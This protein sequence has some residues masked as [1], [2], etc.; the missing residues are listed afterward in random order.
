[1][2]DPSMPPEL[3]PIE[4]LLERELGDAAMARAFA[5]IVVADALQWTPPVVDPAEVESIVAYT[6]GNRI[7]H[8][9]N[10]SP[11]PVNDAL[12]DIVT[13]LHLET[14]APVY[15]QWEIAEAVGDR[16]ATSRLISITPS[17][18]ARGG[19]VYLS[20][21]GVAAAILEKVGDARRL[22]KVAVVGFADHLKRSVDTSRRVGMD[23]AAPAGYDM[24][25]TYDPQSGQ[26]W[27]RSRLVY[28]VHDVCCR[29]EDRRNE[30]LRPVLGPAQGNHP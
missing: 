29:A 7:D 25:N 12:A 27:T 21:G 20:T 13:R 8:N 2:P 23:A 30:L 16:I 4:A 3:Q 17:R 28:L 11:G 5:G 19:T 26:P 15:A 22:G 18:D 1:M 14:G 10:R 9:G 6:F 24:P